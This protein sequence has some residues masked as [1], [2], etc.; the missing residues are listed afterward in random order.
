MT[1]VTSF[2]QTGRWRDW[3]G[4]DIV[5]WALSGYLYFGGDPGREPLMVHNNQALLH[6][7]SHA[8]Y[9][10]LVAL[11][12]AR[13]AGEGQYVDI[14]MSDGVLYLL[15]SSVTTYMMT[16]RAPGRGDFALNG[17]LPQYNV[18]ECSDGGWISLGS[19]EGHF[20]VN[21]CK[22]MDCE[23]FIPHQ[24]DSAKRDEVFAHFRGKFKTK[25]RD[26]WFEILRQTDI[27]VAPVYSLEEALEDPHNV[28]RDMVVEIDHPEAGK[29]KQQYEGVVRADFSVAVQVA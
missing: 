1:S 3:Q 29:V 4:E 15:A 27:C 23:E 24:M 14:A 26:E 7:G 2:G 20:W 17:A 6:A 12:S 22:A 25:T 19:L 28:A 18:Y 9:A 13:K 21:L 10:S 16:G 8:A 11:W 5:S